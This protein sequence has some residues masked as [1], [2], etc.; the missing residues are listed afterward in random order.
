LAK[1][2]AGRFIGG[3]VMADPQGICAFWKGVASDG[4]GGHAVFM[5]TIV[6]PKCGKL[7][8]APDDMAGKHV[9]CGCGTK[10]LAPT[11]AVDEQAP[12]LF[13]ERP[14]PSAFRDSLIPVLSG[15]Y[16]WLERLIVLLKVGGII[17]CILLGFGGVFSIAVGM[18]KGSEQLAFAGFAYLIGAGIELVTSF[19]TAELIR[20][21]LNIEESLTSKP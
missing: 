14:A 15:K 20:V 17:G 18:S 4:R 2:A 3:W 19:A 13:K 11:L 10:F 6:C 21:V 5:L 7:H 16:P 8:D 1:S 9:T 12:I